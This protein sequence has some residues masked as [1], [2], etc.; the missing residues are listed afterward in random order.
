VQQA[1]P[2]LAVLSGEV[3]VDPDAGEARRRVVEELSKPEY[4]A[5]R[6]TW[7]D[8]LSAAVRDWFESLRIG[9]DGPLQWVVIAVVAAVVVAALVTAFLVFGR[10]RLNRRGAAS[11]PLFGTDDARTAEQ[12]RRA[13]ADAASRSDWP[14]A[15]EESYRAIARGLAERTV[16]S[17]SPGTTALGFAARASALF[18]DRAAQLHA[19]A[20]SF[21]GVRYLGGTGSA[22]S[23]RAVAELEAALRSERPASALLPV[24]A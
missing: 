20:A 21:D 24:P 15:I 14:V 19:A 11:A 2:L 6:P 16:L 8:Q 22:E 10:P 18:P 12:M 3:P 4:E 13:A 1:G 17:T 5:A 7:F 9:G 23:Y